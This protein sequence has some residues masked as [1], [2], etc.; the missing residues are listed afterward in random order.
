MSRIS[1]SSFA[2]NIL[3]LIGYHHILMFA[4]TI[5]IILSGESLVLAGCTNSSSFGRSVYVLSLTYQHTAAPPTSTDLFRN[6]S[7][8]LSTASE[9]LDVTVRVGYFG[10]CINDGSGW[11]CHRSVP[12]LGTTGAPN[13]PLMVV[14]M[15]RRYK[16]EVL[17]PGL[18][19]GAMGIS[20]LVIVAL[21]TFP[22]WHEETD[23]ETGSVTEVKPFPS[24][25]VSQCALAATFLASFFTLISAMWQHVSA[26]AAIA[27]LEVSLL[28]VITAHVGAVATAF[29]WLQLLLLV[30]VT[31]GLLVIIVSLAILNELTSD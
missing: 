7:D 25:A 10:L 16:D 15:G 23:E 13:D 30:L 27:T 19:I 5:G 31:L 11:R 4:L 29:V 14:E 18:L 17:F 9:S 21:S 22:G 8:I 20:L 28:G 1:W 24:R 12:G 3:P 6:I 2:S 26:A